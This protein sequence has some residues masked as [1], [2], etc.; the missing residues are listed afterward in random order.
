MWYH[1]LPSP[2][3]EIA[4]G[5]G[6]MAYNAHLVPPSPPAI[7]TARSYTL[8]DLAA[9]EGAG[10]LAPPQSTEPAAA[11]LTFHSSPMRRPFGVPQEA[12]R[13]PLA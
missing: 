6:K 5:A 7:C 9:P 12:H 13:S 2:A 10:A 1:D 8:P 11:I 4:E 3:T